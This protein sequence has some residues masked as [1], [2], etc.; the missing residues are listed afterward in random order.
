MPEG[1]ADQLGSSGEATSMSPIVTHLHTRPQVRCFHN[2]L[3]RGQAAQLRVL[4]FRSQRKAWPPGVRR[5]DACAYHEWL[6]IVMCLSTVCVCA[7][8]LITLTPVTFPCQTLPSRTQER[9]VRSGLS[10]C[11]FRV[12]GPSHRPPRSTFG[13]SS[14]IPHLRRSNTRCCR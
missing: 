9:G 3:C 10:W 2:Q 4:S 12:T 11:S 8:F 6:L 7:T 5:G 13:P 1:P 14:C